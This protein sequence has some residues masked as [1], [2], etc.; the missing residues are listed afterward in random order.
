MCCIRSCLKIPVA[1]VTWG[2]T[3][4]EISAFPQES[5]LVSW[6]SQVCW[7]CDEHACPRLNERKINVVR[8]MLI[9]DCCAFITQRFYSHVSH[10]V[11]LHPY[12]CQT[13]DPRRCPWPNEPSWVPLLEAGPALPHCLG[14][15]LQIPSA[16]LLMSASGTSLYSTEGF[17]R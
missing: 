8:D 14:C 6:A 9:C 2:A 10:D 3:P 4:P 5:L 1:I 17:R 16:A 7:R 15:P 11:D 13:P 12:Q